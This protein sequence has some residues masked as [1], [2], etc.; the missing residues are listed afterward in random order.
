M[1]NNG[2]FLELLAHRNRH[3]P[4]GRTYELPRQ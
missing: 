1:S 2:V 4:E 3:V